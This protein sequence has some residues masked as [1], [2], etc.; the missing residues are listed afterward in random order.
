MKKKILG[1][2]LTACILLQSMSVLAADTSTTVTTA[3]TQTCSVGMTVDST[4]SVIIPK[5]IVLD[6][7]TGVGS[8]TIKCTGDLGYK[9]AIK[10]APATSFILSDGSSNTITATVTQDNTSFVRSDRTVSTGQ[11]T[12]G[13]NVTG[14][15]TATP[16][17]GIWSGTLNF[18]ISIQKLTS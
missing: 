15:I 17:P 4:F 7:T 13:T 12:L 11:V 1:T 3:G 8:Y 2:L 16:E 6:G 14:T 9:D 18:T 5:S 10:V